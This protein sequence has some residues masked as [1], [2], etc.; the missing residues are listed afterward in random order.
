MAI[1][2]D[3]FGGGN[4]I[5]VVVRWHEKAISDF[6][7]NSPKSYEQIKQLLEGKELKCYWLKVKDIEQRI[8]I[9]FQDQ[10]FQFEIYAEWDEKLFSHKIKVKTNKKT[11]VVSPLS[12]PQDQIS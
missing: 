12:I 10:E 1:H 6:N 4:A 8:I 5:E 9:P 2:E 7:K 3:V 11:R